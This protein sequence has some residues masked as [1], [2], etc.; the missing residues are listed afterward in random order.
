[1]TDYS[2]IH[3]RSCGSVGLQAILS[4]GQTPL[5]NALLRADQL[6]EQ[7]P[8]FPLDLVYCPVCSLVQITET[9]PPEQ[10][11]KHYVYFSSFSE[12]ALENAREIATRLIRQRALD[13]N[14]LI[15]EIASNDG[16]LLQYYLES[17]VPVLG[18]EPADNIA[19]HAQKQ[20]VRTLNEFFGTPLA[21]RLAHAD[22]L[23]DVIH[24]NNV[25]AHVADL[26]GVVEGIR[27]VLKDRGVA[28]IEAPYVK[29]LI[30]HT[31]FDTVYHEHLCYFSLTAL[32]GLFRQHDLFIVDVE[33]LPI[34]GGS[35]RIFV[36]KQDIPQDS[37][38]RLLSEEKQ[39]GV[40]QFEFYAR[41]GAKVADLR[42][43]LKACLSDLKA[44]GQKIA[45]Y[46]AS[47]KGST[48]LNYF[49]IRGETLDFVVDR[50][51]AKQSLYT[52][53][54]H[55][56][57]EPP[58]KLVEAMPDYVLLLTWNFADEILRQ[59]SD[60]RARGGKFIIPIPE[61]KIV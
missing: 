16:Y 44:R 8:V 18:I 48:L 23:A 1:M 7:E 32:D 22:T 9:V 55:L 52:P 33:R 5:A 49:G 45:A 19:E 24:A 38:K 40:D 60:Y 27:I 28:V 20:G 59:Q 35:L 11:F 30:D 47:A 29:D 42:E 37:V 53:G 26:N 3:C 13:S 58:Q 36:E 10:L 54:T 21:E 51:T 2:H 57:I 12:T 17:G 6:D 41:F 56:L 46:G 61:V 31:E 34:H 4:L 15:M 14:A 43:Q 39:W 50:S 25:L